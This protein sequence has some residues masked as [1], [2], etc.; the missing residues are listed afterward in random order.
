MK[1]KRKIFIISMVTGIFLLA[2]Y[3][4]LSSV[5]MPRYYQSMIPPE[6]KGRVARAWLFSAELRNASFAGLEAEKIILRFA[7]GTSRLRLI[8]LDGVRLEANWDSSKVSVNRNY[9]ESFLSKLKILGDRPIIKIFNGE[10]SMKF[11]GRPLELPRFSLLL[12][13][14]KNGDISG[15]IQLLDS[16]TKIFLKFNQDAESGILKLAPDGDIRL[17]DLWKLAVESG[18]MTY[19]VPDLLLDGSINLSGEIFLDIKQQKIISSSLKG[20]FSNAEIT[21]GNFEVRQVIPAKVILKGSTNQLQIDVENLQLVK[22]APLLLKK[23]AVKFNEQPSAAAVVSGVLNFAPKRHEWLKYSG[24]SLF[25]EDSPDVKFHGSW[26]LKNKVWGIWSESDGT[27]CEYV[28]S[29][30]GTTINSVLSKLEF[31]ASGTGI[32]ISEMNLLSNAGK[33]MMFS[34]NKHAVFKDIGLSVKYHPGSILEGQINIRD[35]NFNQFQMRNIDVKFSGLLPHLDVA[36]MAESAAVPFENKII[37]LYK[38]SLEIQGDAELG[39]FKNITV[40]ARLP[41]VYA[42]SME[43][44]QVV[45]ETSLDNGIAQGIVNFKD[46]TLKLS[47]T[48]WFASQGKISFRNQNFSLDT[49]EI[50]CL[51]EK[52]NSKFDMVKINAAKSDIKWKVDLNATESNS[53]LAGLIL[54]SGSLNYIVETDYLTSGSDYRLQA[55]KAN[56]LKVDSKTFEATLPK[57][58]LDSLGFRFSDAI[59]DIGAFRL[60][61]VNLDQP[62]NKTG[63]LSAGKLLLNNQMQGKLKAVT[64]FDSSNSSLKIDG[65]QMMSAFGSSE[66]IYNAKIVCSGIDAGFQIPALNVDKNIDLGFLNP[67]WDEV[68]FSGSGVISG[69]VKVTPAQYLSTGAVYFQ[70]AAF[71]GQGWGISSLRG[72]IEFTDWL[73]MVTKPHQKLSFGNMI[74]DGLDLNHGQIIFH[75]LGNNDFLLEHAAFNC[76]W[77]SLSSTAPVKLNFADERKGIDFFA[78]NLN[79]ATLLRRLGIPVAT[80]NS[81]VS[82]RLPLRFKAGQVYPENAVLNS[83]DGNIQLSG[84]EKFNAGASREMLESGQLPFIQAVLANFLYRDLKIMAN[85]NIIKIEASG[86]PAT[87]VP[88]RW[89]AANGHFVKT[90]ISDGIDG[91]LQLETE[92]NTGNL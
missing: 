70:D 76:L 66:L 35:G 21:A 32:D 47:G 56:K 13:S 41:R 84:L 88:F 43:F 31:R 74:I 58:S 33:I 67:A 27:P 5:V 89:N 79:T 22:P 34:E 14:Q 91:E 92:I 38:P 80:G 87:K 36:V 53:T 51:G 90:N 59:V 42:E 48:K 16:S 50:W 2:G 26:N 23:F 46:G 83:S 63:S 37:N 15:K 72:D 81:Q 62:W 85:G 64:A 54:N 73:G 3:L 60:R 12:N 44:S 75:A 7:P 11:F 20:V 9:P 40:K 78:E 39:T 69:N 65:K 68:M 55:F 24:I 28:L 49:A 45:A 29:Y 52:I 19:S 4:I 18:L 6:I 1:K 77:C 17:D 86:R 57:L 25:S 8:I 82:G 61:D 10:C 71:I 30:N